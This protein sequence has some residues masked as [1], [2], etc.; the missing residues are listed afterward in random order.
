MGLF[1]ACCSSP[2]HIVQSET[3]TSSPHI[4]TDETRIFLSVILS[5][6]TEPALRERKRKSKYLV[7]DC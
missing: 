3:G 2:M 6:R 7:G 5:E 1:F 4:H